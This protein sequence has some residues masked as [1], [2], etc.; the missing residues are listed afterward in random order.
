MEGIGAPQKLQ[1]IDE[2]PMILKNLSLDMTLHNLI[3]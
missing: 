3:I 2:L 1:F